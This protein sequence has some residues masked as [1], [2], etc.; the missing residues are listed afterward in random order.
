MYI[1]I[2]HQD[3]KSQTEYMSHVLNFEYVNILN[4]ISQW[5]CG[6]SQWLKK[7]VQHFR[8]MY[9]DPHLEKELALPD[10]SWQEQQ[11]CTQINNQGARNPSDNNRN[12]ISK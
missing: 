11:E 1:F 5:T 6:K 10:P 12:T 3:V 4:G 7:F 9:T 2:H 8:T